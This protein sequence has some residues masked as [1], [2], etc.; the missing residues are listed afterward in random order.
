ML[1]NF[2]QPQIANMAGYWWQQDG[3]TAHTTRASMFQDWIISRNSDFEWPPRSLDL[4]G[5]S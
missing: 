5:I 1:V 4:T 2:V 3:A